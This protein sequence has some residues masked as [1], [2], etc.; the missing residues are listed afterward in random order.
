MGEMVMPRVP[1]V[2]KM[3]GGMMD[4]FNFFKSKPKPGLRSKVDPASWK[5]I[6]VLIQSPDFVAKPHRI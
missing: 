2:D 4:G 5:G 3:S 1:T 6:K